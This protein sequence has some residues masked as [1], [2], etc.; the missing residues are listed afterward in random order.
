MESIELTSTRSVVNL[1]YTSRANGIGYYSGALSLDPALFVQGQDI[2]ILFYFCLD[3]V[4]LGDGAL[5]YESDTASRTLYFSNVT[6]TIRT[7]I[8]E[9]QLPCPTNLSINGVTGGL[10]G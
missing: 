7:T 5:S 9:V 4:P 1:A 2:G 6:L 3:K 10:S 8:T